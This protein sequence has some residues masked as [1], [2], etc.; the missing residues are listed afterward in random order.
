[1]KALP[2]KK[3]DS[4]GRIPLGKEF[5]D[6]LVIVIREAA[7]TLKLIPAEAVPTREAWLYKNPEAMRM[8]ME[9]IEDAKAGRLTN[10]PDLEAGAK[11]VEAIED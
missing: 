9:G 2:V 3:V 7:G 6:T 8:V 11:L 1:M 5:A 4:K 10:G